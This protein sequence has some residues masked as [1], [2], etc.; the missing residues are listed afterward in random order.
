VALLCVPVVASVHHHAI[1]EA[2]PGSCAVCVVAH[3]APVT[4]ASAVS[5]LSLSATPA[6][7]L[8]SPP[9]PLVHRAHS[10]IT[11]RAPPRSFSAFA[12]S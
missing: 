3:H 4:I 11:G 8:A 7:L 10:P 2:A 6:T 5:I 12:I 1:D 9:A